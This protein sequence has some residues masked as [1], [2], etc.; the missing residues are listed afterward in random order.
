MAAKSK[1]FQDDGKDEGTRAFHLMLL[2]IDSGCFHDDLSEAM[3]GMVKELL[4]RWS[5]AGKARGKFTLSLDLT[6]TSGGVIEVEGDHDVKLSP[7]KRKRPRTP[8]WGTRGGNLTLENPKQP[9]LPGVL[10]P[11]PAHEDVVHKIA[12]P[13]GP[14]AVP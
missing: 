10:R 8:F 3:R 4:D 13:D 1:P 6:V 11:V 2:Q 14:R 5:I 9:D 7:K 12:D